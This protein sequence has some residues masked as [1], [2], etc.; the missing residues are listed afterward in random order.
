MRKGPHL[1]QQKTLPG[2]AKANRKGKSIDSPALKQLNSESPLPPALPSKPALQPKGNIPGQLSAA[3]GLPLQLKTLDPPP[4]GYAKK[5]ANNKVW[6]GN[7]EAKV[8]NHWTATAGDK[9]DRN[10]LMKE[11]TIKDADIGTHIHGAVGVNWT[12]NKAN[13]DDQTVL[14]T[15]DPIMVQV[16]GTYMDNMNKKNMVLDF[17]Y[18]NRFP[19]YIIHVKDDGKGLDDHMVEAKPP[20]PA[21]Q[22]SNEHENNPGNA[23]LDTLGGSDDVAKIVGEGG[24]WVCIRDNIG[25][26]HDKTKFYTNAN[27][28]DKL[29]EKVR[30]VTFPYLWKSWAA[31]F[32]KA[33]GIDNA[34]MITKLTP[35]NLAWG[36][37]GAPKQKAISV[38]DST[39]MDTAHDIS[40]D[41]PAPANNGELAVK[42]VS[43]LYYKKDV[44][45]VKSQKDRA[46][47]ETAFKQAL[48]AVAGVTIKEPDGGY[49]GNDYFVAL[50]SYNALPAVGGYTRKA[51]NV[52]LK[53]PHYR[54]DAVKDLA[55]SEAV[56]WGEI[57]A[58]PGVY[59]T[60]KTALYTALINR[61]AGELIALNSPHIGTVAADAAIKLHLR[62]QLVKWV[63]PA[64][65]L[66]D[67]ATNVNT[68]IDGAGVA[69]KLKGGYVKP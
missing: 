69:A 12:A 61:L 53:Y 49:I 17:H 48:G 45:V 47:E 21:G 1:D 63:G 26:L 23:A 7:G 8:A 46:A 16:K 3:P 65:P 25:A 56:P 30:Y 34:T 44:S 59:D 51:A 57:Q 20:L 13:A 27:A 39:D 2:Q 52:I 66:P 19:G 55:K 9:A 60:E 28:Q 10:T 31:S 40:V 67:L 11:M 5:Q 41:N 36:K 38:A 32:G 18:G 62:G 42:E 54:K 14:G 6:F 43:F 24:R 64:D 37:P 50:C 68:L 35:V 22:F 29:T 15:Y 58:G 33:Y 4:A